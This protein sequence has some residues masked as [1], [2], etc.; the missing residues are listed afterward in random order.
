MM[1]SPNDL[2]PLDLT[3]G[4]SVCHVNMRKY[5]VSQVSASN[6]LPC[7]RLL[8]CHYSKDD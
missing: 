3:V 1:R 4:L 2:T 7:M 6:V 5:S 8:C